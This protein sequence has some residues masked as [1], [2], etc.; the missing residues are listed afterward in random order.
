MHA[1]RAFLCRRAW[2]GSRGDLRRMKCRKKYRG[3]CRIGY[4]IGY[5]VDEV[6]FGLVSPVCVYAAPS[7]FTSCRRPS[8]HFTGLRVPSPWVVVCFP[9]SFVLCRVTSSRLFR[10]HVARTGASTVL[11]NHCSRIAQD[12]VEKQFFCRAVVV[13]LLARLGGGVHELGLLC[14]RSTVSR[15]T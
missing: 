8:H 6:S 13:A 1:C 3:E 10:R 12:E 4:R 7:V 15:K 11:V 9:V 2:G 5:R 14:Q